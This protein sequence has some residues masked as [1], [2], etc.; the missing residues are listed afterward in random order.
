M[1]LWLSAVSSVDQAYVWDSLLLHLTS[2]TSGVIQEIV[3]MVL[4]QGQ[5]CGAAPTD[6][7]RVPE[8]TTVLEATW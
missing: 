7:I 3:A 5:V 2:M 6:Q 8:S 4:R 1:G